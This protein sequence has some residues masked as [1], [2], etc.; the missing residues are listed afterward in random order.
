MSCMTGNGT[1]F[2]LSTTTFT[3]DVISI[4]GNEPTIEALDKSHL[5]TTG[6][7]SKCPGD[8]IDQG[9]VTIE[10]FFDPDEIPAIG[11]VETGTITFP[12]PAGKATGAILAG[13]GFI[14]SF[15]WGPAENNTLMRGTL[16]FEYDGETGPAWTASAGST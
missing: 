3:A 13:T 5:G 9:S 12:V 10:F 7:M 6:N 8:L 2:S 4:D 1:T 14:T 16:T 11:V 15:K